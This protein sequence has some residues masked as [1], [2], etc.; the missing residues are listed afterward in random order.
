MHDLEHEID[1][2]HLTICWHPD[3]SFD[4]YPDTTD[5]ARLAERLLKFIVLLHQRPE[6]IPHAAGKHD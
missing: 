6:Y 4:V 2:D 1:G 3:G 5:P